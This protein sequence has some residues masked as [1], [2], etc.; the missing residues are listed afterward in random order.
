MYRMIDRPECKGHRKLSSP[1]VNVDGV[2]TKE[3]AEEIMRQPISYSHAG[4]RIASWN[5]QMHGKHMRQTLRMWAKVAKAHPSSN[6]T[7]TPTP[8]EG[9]DNREAINDTLTEL[10]ELGV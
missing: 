5:R 7:F 3:K 9:V 2:K 10:T 6:F 4:R 8:T 1:N